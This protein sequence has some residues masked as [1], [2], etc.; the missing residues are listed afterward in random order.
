MVSHYNGVVLFQ[1]LIG[2]GFQ[3]ELQL[4]A[5][6]GGRIE[7][8]CERVLNSLQ[9]KSV[10]RL[11]VYVVNLEVLIES[12]KR[13]VQE[14]FAG[15]VEKLTYILIIDVNL[16]ITFHLLV[17]PSVQIA[18]YHLVADTLSVYNTRVEFI[19]LVR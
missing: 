19:V 16:S 10:L 6:R 17:G 15:G 7:I 18:G 11:A 14:E 4:I 2:T 13:Q 8:D 12:I 1:S 9:D 5:D 3:R